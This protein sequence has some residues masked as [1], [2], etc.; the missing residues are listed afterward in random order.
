MRQRRLTPRR[1]PVHGRGVFALRSIA[2]GERLIEYAGEVTSW[3]S[4]QL[5]TRRGA[6]GIR[7][8]AHVCFWSIG[9][10]GDRWQPWR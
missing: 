9:R 1:S 10:S 5:A 8:R 6:S 4:D 2:A 7:A 3:R